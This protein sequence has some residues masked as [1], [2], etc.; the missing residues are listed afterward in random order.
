MRVAIVGSRRFRDLSLVRDYVKRLPA[1]DTVV[2]GGAS[3]VDSVAEYS[4]KFSGYPVITF[5]VDKSGL[6]P[7]GTEESRIEYARRAY[8]RNQLIA[9][10]CDRLVAFW[11]GKSGG[12]ADVIR[13]AEA[14]GKPVEVYYARPENIEDLV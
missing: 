4:A 3:G 14:L 1:G 12:T 2:S 8:R 7:Y 10:N 5:P 6:P 13:R 11:D 9:E